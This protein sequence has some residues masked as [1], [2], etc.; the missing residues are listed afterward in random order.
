MHDVSTAGPQRPRV[1]KALG[2][3]VGVAMLMT[4][5]AIAPAASA[6]TAAG[7]SL[8]GMDT[9]LQGILE[10]LPNTATHPFGDGAGAGGCPV[11][12]GIGT[13]GTCVVDPLGPSHPGT[14]AKKASSKAKAKAKARRIH[15]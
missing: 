12:D 14:T 15:R 10:G 11:I 2:L 1:R 8:G 13:L 4:P 9:L 3:A 6:Q 7:D 5:L